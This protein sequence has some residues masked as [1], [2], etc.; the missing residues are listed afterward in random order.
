MRTSVAGM[1]TL[2]IYLVRQIDRCSAIG[3]EQH[4][5]PG[6]A[7]S[8]SA[9]TIFVRFTHS[10]VRKWFCSLSLLWILAVLSSVAEKK[11]SNIESVE[12]RFPTAQ[13]TYVIDSWQIS[14]LVQYKMSLKVGFD[15]NTR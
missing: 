7:V 12:L 14:T 5:T 2:S 10:A 9:W 15:S 3:R 8:P 6:H 11:S 4:K 1:Q 13:Y